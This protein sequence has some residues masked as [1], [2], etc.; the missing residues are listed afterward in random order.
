MAQELTQV[1]FSRVCKST[2]VKTSCNALAVGAT[3]LLYHTEVG[4]SWSDWCSI[5]M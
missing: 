1:L 5:V 2:R 4:S 3:I